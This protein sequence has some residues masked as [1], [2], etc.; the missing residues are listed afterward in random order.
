MHNTSCTLI[1]RYS[2]LEVAGP[3]EAVAGLRQGVFHGA[4]DL[5]RGRT[6]RN[7]AAEV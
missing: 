7:D 2:K 5:D 1:G 3:I 6:R 4:E